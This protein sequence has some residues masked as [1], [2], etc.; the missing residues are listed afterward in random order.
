MFEKRHH[1]FVLL[2]A[3][4][5]SEFGTN[6]RQHALKNITIRSDGSCLTNEVGCVKDSS[7]QI[8]FLQ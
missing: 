3:A 2:T 6:H 8:P 7:V 5:S 1:R 4:N